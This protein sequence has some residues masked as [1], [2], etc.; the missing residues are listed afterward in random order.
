VGVAGVR[1]RAAAQGIEVK[2]DADLEDAVPAAWSDR[3]EQLHFRGSRAFEEVVFFHHASATLVL[4]DL[5]ENFERTK[6]IRA[7]R[8]LARFGGV[9]DPDGKTPSDMRMTFTDRRAA[10]ACLQQ[11]LA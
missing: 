8:V 1:E 10:R 4:A 7:M 6:L 11:I 3:I 9:L 2:F 5:V